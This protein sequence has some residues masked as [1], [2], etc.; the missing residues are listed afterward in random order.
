MIEK[1][2]S[3]QWNKCNMV[4]SVLL[5]NNHNYCLQH[6]PLSSVFFDMYKILDPDLF[7]SSDV[8][9]WMFL[10][11]TMVNVQNKSGWKGTLSYWLYP[12]GHVCSHF[13]VQCR[14]LSLVEQHWMGIFWHCMLEFVPQNTQWCY[15]WVSKIC[16][17][18]NLQQNSNNLTH[19]GHRLLAELSNILHYE[20]VPILTKVLT[21]DFLLLLLYLSRTTIP[22]NIP[23]GYLLQRIITVLFCVLCCLHSRWSWWSRS[24]DTTMLDI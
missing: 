2:E 4:L 20:T 19:T 8:R 1:A 24:W 7:K 15:V 12:W 17:G 11:K 21:D 14:T 5:Y 6:C 9:K 18:I 22:T 16:G 23:F 3:T 13:C 10:L